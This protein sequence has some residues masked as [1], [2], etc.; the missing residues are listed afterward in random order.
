[1]HQTVLAEAFDPERFF[2]G[3][4]VEA[5]ILTIR[6]LG[7]D[8]DFP[9]YA[10]ALY[11]GCHDA[12]AEGDRSCRDRL[13][14]RMI[15]APYDGEPERPRWRGTRLLEDL[16]T[17]GVSS[18]KELLKA[19]DDGAVEWLEADLAT[20]PAALNHAR[21]TDELRWFGEPLIQEPSDEIAIIMHFDTI[22]V[23]F[24]PNYF[25]DFR[26]QGHVGDGL[27]SGWADAFAKSLESCWKPATATRPWRRAVAKPTGDK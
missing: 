8:Y 15:R 2:D 9:V 18:R 21:S 6:Y 10:I 23:R 19:L 4:Y 5:P 24:R 17:R 12:D 1:M 27:P 22:D 13:Q 7:D 14:A 11:K 25:T 16:H 3:R 26:Y 20:C